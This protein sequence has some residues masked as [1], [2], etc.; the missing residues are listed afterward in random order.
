MVADILQAMK[1]R[2]MVGVNLLEID[3][4]ARAMIVDAGAQSC[5]VDYSPSFGR[6]PLGTTSARPSMTL[7]SMDCLTTTHLLTATSCPRTSPFPRMGSLRTPLS[8][9]QW[10]IQSPWTA[11]MIDATER[12]LS[13]GIAVAGPGARIGDI[14]HAIGSVLSAAGY[15]IN[16]Q[17]GGHGIGS[18]M[19]QTRTSPM[20][21][22]RA[23]GTNCVPDYCWHWSLGS[24]RTPPNS[25]P[26][27][28][29]GR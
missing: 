1:S 6:G 2:S 18:T 19:H 7:Y 4:W 20:P 25:L 24:W 14:S 3:Q 17:F 21:G 16:T 12:A 10:A 15:P 27:T 22:G 11:A 28:T 23:V 26:T 8:A 29:A 9:S 13:A 5:Y